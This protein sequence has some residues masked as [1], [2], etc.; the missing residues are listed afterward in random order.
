[1]KEQYGLKTPTDFNKELER[2]GEYIKYVSEEM[3]E[4]YQLNYSRTFLTFETKSSIDKQIYDLRK[5][6]MGYVRRSGRTYSMLKLIYLYDLLNQGHPDEN[7]P[8]LLYSWNQNHSKDLRDMAETILPYSVFKKLQ[9]LTMKEGQMGKTR[10]IKYQF[11]ISDHYT[12]EN[13][14]KL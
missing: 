1:M 14:K 13:I 12:I 6:A 2:L 7:L 8:I 9:I 3:V 4:Q 5:T 10:G 11:G